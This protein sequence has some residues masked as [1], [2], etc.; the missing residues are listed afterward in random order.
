MLG[1]WADEPAARPGVLRHLRT[2]GG[3]DVTYAHGTPPNAAPDMATMIFLDG[4]MAKGTVARY[5]LLDLTTM[6]AYSNSY[7]G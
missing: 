1:P 4:Q 2:R 6:R 5:E 7:T 3:S